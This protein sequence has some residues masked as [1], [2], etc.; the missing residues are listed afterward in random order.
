MSAKVGR[1]PKPAKWAS[2]GMPAR[3]ISSRPFRPTVTMVTPPAWSTISRRVKRTAF[4]VSGPASGRSVVIRTTRRLPAG[5]AVARRGCSSPLRTAATS[6][7]TSSSFSLYG[8]AARVASWARLSLLAATNC[9]AR[10]IWRMFRTAPM[11]R[12]MSRW[13]ATTLGQEVLAVDLDRLVKRRRELIA[14]GAARGEVGQDLGPLR[15]E[16]AVEADLPVLDPVRGD[17]VQGALRGGV[18]DRDLLLDAEGLV[19][20]LLDHFGQL[21]AAG[22]LV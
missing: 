6:A 2:I 15:L 9:I 10:V 12:R 3:R 21:L 20:G 7:S 11:R 14:Q 17:V 18:Q 5:S 13:L 19:L 22:Q 16:E 8:R 4:E 1:S